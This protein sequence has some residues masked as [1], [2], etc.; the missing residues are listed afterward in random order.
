MRRGRKSFARRLE[1]ACCSI[2][3]YFPLAFVYGVTTW[4]VWVI[5]TMGVRLDTRGMASESMSIRTMHADVLIHEKRLPS[6]S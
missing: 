2:I 5:G 1:R 3:T 6:P 4:A